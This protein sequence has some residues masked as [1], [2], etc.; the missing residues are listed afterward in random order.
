MI[1][2]KYIYKELTFHRIDG[3]HSYCTDKEGR[4]FHIGASTEVEIV[5][6]DN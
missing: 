3:A 5:T 4:V 6:N 2:K 1:L